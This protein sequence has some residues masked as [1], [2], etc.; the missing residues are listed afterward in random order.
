VLGYDDPDPEWAEDDLEQGD[1]GDLRS[2]E[3]PCTDGEEGETEP[4]LPEA[5]DDEQ[6]E[7]VRADLARRRERR[8]DCEDEVRLNRRLAPGRIKRFEFL[9]K[10]PEE[11]G[12]VEPGLEQFLRDTALSGDITEAEI[13]FLGRLKF[14]GKSPSPLYYYRELQ[15]LRDPLHF[16]AASQPKRSD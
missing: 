2:R 5:E 3:E 11:G 9:E 13:D 7:V 1:E 12:L 14:E 15:N 6:Y 4:H 16:T 8:R 10:E